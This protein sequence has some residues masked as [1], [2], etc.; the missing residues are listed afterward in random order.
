MEKKMYAVSYR[1]IG[2]AVSLVVAVFMYGLLAQMNFKAAVILAAAGIGFILW[3]V[4]MRLV[5]FM[6]KKVNPI[7]DMDFYLKLGLTAFFPIWGMLGQL[8]MVG[9]LIL[10]MQVV[11]AIH[12]MALMKKRNIY[13]KSI[14]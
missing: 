4:N 7:W 12:G 1:T 3:R 11:Y 9:V 8:P 6:F 14:Y 13:L 5:N 2:I 10:G